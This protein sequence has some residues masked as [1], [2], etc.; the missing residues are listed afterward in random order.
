MNTKGISVSKRFE[1]AWQAMG[2]EQQVCK[3]VFE[4]LA[5]RENGSECV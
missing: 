5:I 1:V 2:R 4:A 3:V